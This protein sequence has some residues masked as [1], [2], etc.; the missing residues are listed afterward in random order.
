MN[1]IPN[2]ISVLNVSIKYIFLIVVK[3]KKKKTNKA[4]SK[5]PQERCYIILF[6]LIRFVFNK[7]IVKLR[8][9]YKWCM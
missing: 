1:L 6:D 5:N 4:Y 9:L 8:F 2:L 7:T 3:R